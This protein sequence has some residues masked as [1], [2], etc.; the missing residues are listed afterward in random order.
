VDAQPSHRDQRKHHNRAFRK[1][2]GRRG[3]DDAVLWNSYKVHG[4]V[5][6]RSAAIQ[7]SL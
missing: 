6:R 3:P 1:G 7:N 5:E 4:D 2:C